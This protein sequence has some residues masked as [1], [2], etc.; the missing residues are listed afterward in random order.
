LTTAELAG[1]QSLL[2]RADLG[3]YPLDAVAVRGRG[4]VVVW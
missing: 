1:V 4:R 2:C 3:E